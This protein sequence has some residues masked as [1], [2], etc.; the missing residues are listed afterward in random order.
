MGEIVIKKWKCD[1]CGIVMAKWSRPV[2][3][4]EVTICQD[5]DVGPGPRVFWK[6]M[7]CACTIEVS[8]EFSA[9]QESAKVARIAIEQEPRGD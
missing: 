7:C 8:G 3:C 2:P 5:Y 1:R 4:I 6:E 9:M